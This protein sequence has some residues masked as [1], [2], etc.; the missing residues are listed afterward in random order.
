MRNVFRLFQYGVFGQ[1]CDIQRTALSIIDF[2]SFAQSVQ[3]AGNEQRAFLVAGFAEH[4]DIR[5]YPGHFIRNG[6]EAVFDDCSFHPD[7]QVQYSQ[8]LF[9]FRAAAADQHEQP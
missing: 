4:Y 1:Q 8:L 7:V 9:L 6:L 2:P 5:I 3:H